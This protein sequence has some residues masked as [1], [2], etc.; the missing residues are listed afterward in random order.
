M[1]VSQEG[2]AF[3]MILKSRESKTKRKDELSN[4]Q[5]IKKKDIKK[6]IFGLSTWD[7]KKI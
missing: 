3:G 4:S 5:A 7:G 6:N 1:D 2:V